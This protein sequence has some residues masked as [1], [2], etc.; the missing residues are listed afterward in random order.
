MRGVWAETPVLEELV[1]GP[2][3]AWIKQ[4]DLGVLAAGQGLPGALFGVTAAIPQGEKEASRAGVRPG[5]SAPAWHL[6]GCG[7]GT[8]SLAVPPRTESASATDGSVAWEESGTRVV[9]SA[10][11][12][13]AP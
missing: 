11:L 3:H 8:H 12:S 13:Q 9:V 10:V 1:R 7:D 2:R 6:R 4:E 5:A